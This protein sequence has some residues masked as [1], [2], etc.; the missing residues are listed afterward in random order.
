MELTGNYIQQFEI[1]TGTGQKGDWQATTFMIE[2]P[3]Q[4]PKKPIF[5]LFNNQD[6]IEGLKPGDSITVHFDLDSS[7]W[8]GKHF[9]KVKAFKVVR[10]QQQQPA[11]QQPAAFAPPAAQQEIDPLPF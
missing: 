3:G 9:P 6:A 10:N 5:E 7:E 2:V 11:T 8:Q 1:K 4:Y